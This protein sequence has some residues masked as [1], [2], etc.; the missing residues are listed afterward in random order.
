MIGY[1]LPR[2]ILQFNNNSTKVDLLLLTAT[3]SSTITMHMR[4]IYQQEDN[5]ILYGTSPTFAWIDFVIT[6]LALDWLPSTR[7]TMT[8]MIVSVVYFIAVNG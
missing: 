1:Y 2:T 3:S 4:D 8:M 5:K 6:L 7:S